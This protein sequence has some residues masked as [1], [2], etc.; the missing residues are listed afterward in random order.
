MLDSRSIKRNQTK[1]LT[2]LDES[3]RARVN[4]KSRLTLEAVMEWG[5]IR[6]RYPA[7][8]LLVEALEAHSEGGYRMMNK[9]AVLNTYADSNEAF[10]E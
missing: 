9:I 10:Q 1:G 8:W 4:V 7:Q 6:S 2:V 3:C 5:E